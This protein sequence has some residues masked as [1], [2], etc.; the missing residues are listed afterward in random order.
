M[1]FINRFITYYIM[2]KIFIIGFLFLS[3]CL[4]LYS[5]S[6]KEAYKNVEDYYRNTIYKEIM[7]QRKLFD[8]N[9]SED[10]RG[11]L[12]NLRDTIALYDGKIRAY[13]LKA[14]EEDRVLTIKERNFIQDFRLKKNRRIKPLKGIV[15]KYEKE[16]TES[17]EGFKSFR[18]KWKADVR[19]LYGKYLDKYYDDF[20]FREID[21]T[22][23][24]LLDP[25]KEDNLNV[26]KRV[27]YM[28]RD[29]MVKLPL[30]Q[31]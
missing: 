23:F 17:R 8:K 28:P 27:L 19:E 6:E 9:I 16:L 4:S 29:V 26:L 2:K 10:D 13:K 20:P 18:E 25:N 5:Q 15:E 7:D 31:R 1:E 3:S 14:K 21:P 30:K 12:S 22:M 24:I 11:L